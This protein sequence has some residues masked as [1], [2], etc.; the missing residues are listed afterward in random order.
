MIDIS[1]CDEKFN[2]KKKIKLPESCTYKYR[3]KDK[4]PID[5]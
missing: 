3:E 2:L 4:T 1:I 5:F